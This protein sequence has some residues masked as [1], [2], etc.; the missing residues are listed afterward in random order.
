MALP[1]AAPE[2]ENVIPFQ[3]S[4]DVPEGDGEKKTMMKKMMVWEPHPICGF[5]VGRE[6]KS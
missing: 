5:G 1:S 6:R 4:Q 3:K 2:V